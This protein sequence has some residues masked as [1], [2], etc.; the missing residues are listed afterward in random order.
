[1]CIF[2]DCYIHVF[3]RIID[4]FYQRFY[5]HFQYIVCICKDYR[6]DGLTSAAPGRAR[7]VEASPQR[8]S[9][10]RRAPQRNGVGAAMASRRWRE[11]STIFVLH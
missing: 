2:M 3:V 11:A 8:G 5:E 1:M 4:A 7:V 9:P 10:R 6:S